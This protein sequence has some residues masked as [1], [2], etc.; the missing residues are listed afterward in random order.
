MADSAND[1]YSNDRKTPPAKSG[2]ESTRVSASQEGIWSA[3]KEALRG[4]HRN[5]T[6]GSV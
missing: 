6:E 4:S 5:Y 3:V 1:Q 2:E